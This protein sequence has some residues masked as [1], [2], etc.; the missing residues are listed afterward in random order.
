M[1]AKAYGKLTPVA[2]FLDFL[3][4]NFVPFDREASLSHPCPSWF[5]TRFI[6]FK[7][8]NVNHL[9]IAHRGVH[10]PD[11]SCSLLQPHAP[12]EHERW[13]KSS[14]WALAVRGPWKLGGEEIYGD[15]LS[16]KM[17]R[18]PKHTGD[19]MRIQ[20]DIHGYTSD[21]LWMVAKFC[22]TLKGWNP[23]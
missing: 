23:L 19:V 15:L 7:P 4:S 10:P 2:M 11:H 22:T 9:G 17:G 12:Q 18:K 3:E 1:H 16:P 5:Q 6:K 14:T 21:I 8:V 20:W 13:E